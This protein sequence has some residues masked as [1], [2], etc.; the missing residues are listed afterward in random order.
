MFLIISQSSFRNFVLTFCLMLSSIRYN[1]RLQVEALETCTYEMNVYNLKHRQGW[2][3]LSAVAKNENW[4]MINSK[5]FLSEPFGHLFTHRHNDTIWVADFT[6]A[7]IWRK[8]LL[9]LCV[10]I[11]RSV[12]ESFKHKQKLV[13][14]VTITILSCCWFLRTPSF[15][16]QLTSIY[17]A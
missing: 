2:K 16:K 11:R 10:S 12:F 1:Q 17:I 8:K 3:F 5:I 13:R 14:I 9:L 6:P 7:F 15:S 4:R